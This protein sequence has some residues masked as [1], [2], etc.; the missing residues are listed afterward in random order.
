[1]VVDDSI[2]IRTNLASMLQ[3]HGCEVLTCEDGFEALSKAA[4]FAPNLVFTDIVMPKVDGYE[5]ISLLRANPMFV[6]IPIITLSSKSG[7]FDI[8]RGKLIGCDDYI[9]KPVSLRALQS[10][11]E[12]H[13]PDHVPA[14]AA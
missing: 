12:R 8:A 9:T 2:T 7:V 14:N 13:L 4:S 1:M 3:N 5:L 11:L 6:R 10:V